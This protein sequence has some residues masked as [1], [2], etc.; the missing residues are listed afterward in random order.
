M[1]FVWKNF[2]SKEKDEK[3]ISDTHDLIAIEKGVWLNNCVR[4]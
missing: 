1:E 4:E 3:P 2:Y